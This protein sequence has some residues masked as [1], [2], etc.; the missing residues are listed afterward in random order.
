M[1]RGGATASTFNC[2]IFPVQQNSA[3]GVSSK[4]NRFAW[5]DSRKFSLSSGSSDGAAHLEPEILSLVMRVATE[6]GLR[7][8]CHSQGW[9]KHSAALGRSLR[10]DKHQQRLYFGFWTETDFYL[11]FS[12]WVTPVCTVIILSLEILFSVSVRLCLTTRDPL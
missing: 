12:R 1:E 10:S 4:R 3:D 8:S 7:Q 9:L 11:T 5:G 2:S 6:S